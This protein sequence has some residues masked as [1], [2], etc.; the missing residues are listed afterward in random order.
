MLTKKD[1]KK[2]MYE[3]Y[4]EGTDK[5]IDIDMWKDLGDDNVWV[6]VKTKSGVIYFYDINDYGTEYQRVYKG[7]VSLSTIETWKLNY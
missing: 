6:L 3:K 5:I 2:M 4:L 1:V 7:I